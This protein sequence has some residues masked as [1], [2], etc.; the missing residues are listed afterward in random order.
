MHT[1]VDRQV[2]NTLIGASDPVSF[3]LDLFANLKEVHELFAFTMEKLAILDRAVDQLKN[4]GSS[5]DN[6]ATSWKKIPAKAHQICE[7]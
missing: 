1:K 3:I 6:S 4:K 2:R 5:S 7:L